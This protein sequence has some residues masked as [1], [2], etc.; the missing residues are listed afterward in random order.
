[1]KWNLQ[2]K[3]STIALLVLL[4]VACGLYAYVFLGGQYFSENTQEDRSVVIENVVGIVKP[5]QPKT[6]VVPS[7][8]L[9]ADVEYVGVTE[10]GDMGTPSDY[11]DVAW[12]EPG[13]TPGERGNAVFAGHLDWAGNHGAFW[14]LHELEPGDVVLVKGKGR[15]L[16]YKV[17]GS[18]KYPYQT[19]HT[20]EIFGKSQTSQIKLITCDGNY[21]EGVENYE[22]RLV[23]TAVLVGE[24]P[25]QNIPD[26]KE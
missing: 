14:S 9:K 16:R 25:E 26:T 5:L 13:Y 21:D 12:Y 22:K 2:V 4:V 20:K 6:L 18:K 17:I 11:H 24:F 7:I 3:K 19:A 10:D 23:V 15:T 8:D 1:M